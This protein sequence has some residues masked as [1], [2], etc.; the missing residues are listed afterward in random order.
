MN[1]L[2][3]KFESKLHELPEKAKLELFDAQYGKGKVV[4]KNEGFDWAAY[5]AGVEIMRGELPE[6]R[7]T[8][9][10]CGFNYAIQEVEP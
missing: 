7:H 9:K 5:A 4:I 2:I 6:V 3:Y 8:I 1:N 10:T